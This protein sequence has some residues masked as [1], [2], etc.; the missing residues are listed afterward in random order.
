MRSINQ[1]TN[2]STCCKDAQLVCCVKNPLL[3][4]LFPFSIGHAGVIAACFEVPS[5]T[6]RVR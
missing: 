4:R 6:S 2:Q 5:K 1:S 3:P